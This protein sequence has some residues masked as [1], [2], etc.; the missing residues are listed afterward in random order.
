MSVLVPALSVTH[1]I[2]SVGSKAGFASIIGL[3]I[4]VL[5]YFAHARETASLRDQLAESAQRTAALEA[6]LSQLLRSQTP[7][8]PQQPAPGTARPSPAASPPP[9]ARPAVAAATAG[10]SPGPG[11]APANPATP[12]PAAMP[13]APAVAAAAAPAARVASPGPVAAPGTAVAEPPVAPAGVGAPPLRDATR[14]IPDAPVAAPSGPAPQATPPPSTAAAGGN[15]VSAAARQPTQPPAGTAPPRVRIG[16]GAQP[17][18][19]HAP[20]TRAVAPAAP[21]RRRNV[22]LA[23]I[24]LLFVAGVIAV[25]L[26]VTSSGGSSS[27]ASS[28]AAQTSNAPAT[29]HSAA[30]PKAAGFNPAS[31]TVAVLNGT[32]TAGRAHRVAQ[33][34]QA[35]GYKL[36]RVAT[37]T[38]Q[39]HTATVVAYLPGFRTDAVR[40]AAL[41]KLGPASAAPIDPSTQ[42]LA[43]PAGSPCTA[44]VTVG[45]DLTAIP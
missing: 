16:A 38:D 3:A 17:P 25:L 6:R 1:F 19:R 10:A 14:L 23:A 15:G 31:V 22:L 18:R 9:A 28:N 35:S 8:P 7:A 34:L 20:P 29:H 27:S 44:V 4:L 5:L 36:G 26:V 24:G 32:P 43:C 41:L 33:K 11:A 2:N 13:I 40:V 12:P 42:A 37:A 30:K 39:T 21:S 45:T